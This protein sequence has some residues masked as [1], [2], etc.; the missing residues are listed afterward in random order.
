[1]RIRRSDEEVEIYRGTDHVRAAA[2]GLGHA[3]RRC[4]P[5]VGRERR[6]VYLWKKK[7]GNLGVTEMRQLRQLQDENVRLKRLVA[8]LTLDRHILQEVI[9]KKA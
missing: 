1:M 3:D 7:Y 6:H 9:K 8:D 4:V 2:G 5:A